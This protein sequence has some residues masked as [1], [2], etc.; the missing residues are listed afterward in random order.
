MG[1]SQFLNGDFAGAA[2]TFYYI[3]RHFSLGSRKS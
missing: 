1:R 3:S 2:A